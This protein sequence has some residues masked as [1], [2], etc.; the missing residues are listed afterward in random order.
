MAGETEKRTVEIIVNGQKAHAS[1]KEMD[2]AAAVLYNQFRKLSA[3]DP[4]RAKL[5]ADYH[6]LKGRV[7]D[8]RAELKGV[9]ESTGF[10]KQGFANAFAIFTGGGL[11]EV[12]QKVWGFLTSSREEY[13]ASARITADLENTLRSTAHAAGLTA[14]EIKA[15]GEARAKVTLFD[16]DESNAAS[17]MLLTFTNI[18]KGVFEDALP[19]IQDIATKMAGDGPADLKGASIQVGK[20]LNDPIKGITALTRVG[21]TFTEAQK[22]QITQM[23]KAGNTAGAQKLILSELN[24]EFG[25]SAEAARKAAGG[26]ATLSMRWGEFK[27]TVGEKVSAGLNAASQWFGELLDKSQPIV[28]VFVELWTEA[29]KL[30]DSLYEIAEGLGLVSSS[31]NSAGIVAKVLTTLFTLLLAPIKAVYSIVNFLADGFINLYNKS[32]I[33]RGS[34]GGLVEVF[35][36]IAK[37]AWD[38]LGGVADLLVGIFTLDTDKIKAGLK[39][40]FDS[41][42]DLTYKAGANAAGNFQ[43]GYALSKD[44]RIV[45]KV[46]VETET[47]GSGEGALPTSTNSGPAELS[48]KERQKAEKAREAALKK[49]QDAQNKA[50]QTRLN[51]L[52]KQVEFESKLE[53]ARVDAISDGHEREIAGVLLKYRRKAALVEG[54]EAEQAMQLSA[55]REDQER[56]LQALSAKYQKKADDDK[57]DRFEKRL[58]EEDSQETEREAVI[59]A[60][61]EDLLITEEQR[62]Q[63]LYEAKRASLEA[64]LAMEEAYG[65]K[66][67]ALYMK[68]HKELEKLDR[69]ATK[70]AEANAK[71]RADA[72]T[73]FL[74]MTMKT[75]TDALQLTIDILSRDEEARKRNAGL[76]RSFTMAKLILD[77]TQEIQGIWTDAAQNPFWKLLP[78]GASTAYAIARSAIAA[79]RTGFAVSQVKAQQ[80]AKGGRTGSG[81]GAGASAIN[82]MGQLMEM[83]GVSVA[84]NG[85][86]VDNTGFAVAGIVHQDEYVIPKWMREDPQVLAVENWL[87]AKRLRGYAEGG[88]TTEGGSQAVAPITVAG[89][90]TEL[91]REML[92]VLGRLDHRLVGVESWRRDLNVSLNILALEK[93]QQMLDT[94]RVES[95]IRKG[96]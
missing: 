55:I 63:M 81:I 54:T 52:K 37:S 5:L 72:M 4:G 32:E 65:G 36:S 68:T 35:K 71:K 33:F 49:A 17:A 91:M 80:F 21:V 46:S 3:D 82:P 76:I 24:K 20:A 14:D 12:V 44:K 1:L 90:D 89:T 62:D 2:A 66:T 94:L 30:Y 95:A 6:E 86:L 73:K 10:L 58:A 26:M 39:L 41:L 67:S 43:A 79:V 77:G 56:E 16:D 59:Q 34:V 48:E 69:A 74:E 70:E 93:E 87:E 83:S 53:D 51:A 45:R 31:G 61:F 42:S 78:P 22:E 50:D 40:T 60:K 29:A 13:Q 15:I 64:K 23:V 18:K 27:E 96:D 57:K 9:S 84:S 28:D 8:V 85:K 38:S 47:S 75:Q 7:N 19:A 92:S 25:G 88:G 11:L